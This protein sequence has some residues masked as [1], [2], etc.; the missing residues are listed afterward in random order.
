MPLPIGHAVIGFTTQ[1]LFSAEESS[2]GRWKTLLGV[3]I[4]SNLPDVDVLLGIVFHGNGNVFHRGPTHSLM[5]ALIGGFLATRVLRLWSQLPKFG[6][7]IC[8]L[9][10]LSHVVAD[11]VFTNS[12][13]SF[14]WPITVNWSNGYIELR[15]VVNLVLFGNH[16]DAEII[17]GC[18]FLILLHRTFVGVGTIRYTQF[19]TAFLRRSRYKVS[20]K[21]KTPAES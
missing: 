17:I 21:T 1:S 7:R 12:P 5:F 6:F 11:L 20:E 19:I 2:S 13:V 8:F 9:F 18:V 4:L 10:I 15:H 3:L 16:R 14:F